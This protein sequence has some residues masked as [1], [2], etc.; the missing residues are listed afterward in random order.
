MHYAV[1]SVWVPYCYTVS[2]AC[3][4]VVLKYMSTSKRV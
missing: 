2:I 3:L 1:W 4:A